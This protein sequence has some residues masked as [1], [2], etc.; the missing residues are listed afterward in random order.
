MDYASSEAILVRVADAVVDTLDR[1]RESQSLAGNVA[2]LHSDDL[3]PGAITMRSANP[4]PS[5]MQTTNPSFGSRWV[6]LAAIATVLIFTFSLASYFAWIQPKQQEPNVQQTSPSAE[7]MA[8]QVTIGNYDDDNELR[9]NQAD[10][11]KVGYSNSEP[12]G[13]PRHRQLRFP[14]A[15]REAAKEAADKL[16]AANVS[17]SPVVQR[18]RPE[19]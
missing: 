14:F 5:E 6:I 18:Y 2:T 1:G 8:W 4:P 15:S 17:D 9:R 13:P 16:K 3:I 10:A 19:P 11:A 12:F 7:P